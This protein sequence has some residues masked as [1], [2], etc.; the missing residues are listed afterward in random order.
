VSEVWVAPGN[1]GTHAEPRAG[2]AA[3]RALAL[4]SLDPGA[5]VAQARSVRAD[6]VVVGPEAPLCAGAI[7]ALDDARIPAFGPKRGAA[8]LEASKAFTKRLCSQW[9][10]PTAPY[11]IT[12]DIDEAEH[13]I[14]ASA[15]ALVVKADGLAAGKGA[16]VTSS[17]AEARAAARLML[18]DQALG[19]AGR[20]IVIEERLEGSELSVHALSDG[21]R[22][23]ILPVARDHKRMRDGDEG[24][25]TGGM[26]AFA[27]VTVDP[28]LLAR[29]E[30][31]VLRPTLEGMSASGHTYRGV[32]YAGLMIAPD[33]TPYLLEHNVRFGDPETQVLM[34]LIDGDVAA[35]FHSVTRGQLD[36]SSVS[37][38]DLHAVVVVMAASGYPDAPRKGDVIR[39]VADGAL[40]EGAHVF[41]AGTAL[42]DGELVSAGGRVLGVAATGSSLGEAKRRAYEAASR[43]HFDGMHYRR[44]IAARS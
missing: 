36:A 25:N 43:I 18:V 8:A 34:L 24:P 13:Y 2:H 7:D 23:W 21:E 5:I 41:H 40:V 38:P 15:K 27:P 22:L 20:T 35:L 26:G 42:R 14:D 31:E 1:A 44:D 19:E 37:L 39:G 10:I 29:I 12:S 11:L 28:A 16:V 32:L 3:V 9:N 6:L 17:A 30:R 33:G 4:P